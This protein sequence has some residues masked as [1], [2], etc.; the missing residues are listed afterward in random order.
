MNSI[1]FTKPDISTDE[2]VMH[3]T[4]SLLPKNEITGPVVLILILSDS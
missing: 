1:L 4:L 3:L 2:P